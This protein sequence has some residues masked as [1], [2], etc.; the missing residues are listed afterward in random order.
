ML[1]FII[2]QSAFIFF[3]SACF[4]IFQSA[5]IF[6][7]RA[8]TYFR[9]P[10]VIFLRLLHIAFI[11][12]HST[13]ILFHSA[14]IVFHS[15]FIFLAKS[16]YSIFLSTRK[17]FIIALLFNFSKCRKALYHS[18]FIQFFLSA[19]KSLFFILNASQRLFF[20]FLSMDQCPIFYFQNMQLLFQF[21]DVKQTISWSY[22]FII[23][24][25]IFEYVS[26]A[27]SNYVQNF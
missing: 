6:C 10:C 13:F 2:F 7:Q 27:S 16:F 25:I 4:I 19:S 3:Q 12:F 8:F 21:L 9:P 14:F 20:I 18:A 1:Q 23:F 17:H 11:L 24:L 22:F 15:A 26:N 5:F